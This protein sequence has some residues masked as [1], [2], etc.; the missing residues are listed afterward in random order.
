MIQPIAVMVPVCCP[1]NPSV[2]G[3]HV[4]WQ[5]DGWRDIDTIVVVGSGRARCLQ[6]GPEFEQLLARVLASES[7]TEAIAAATPELI[8]EQLEEDELAETDEM[9][10]V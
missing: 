2:A 9:E 5:P 8:R 7:C 4:L 1:D 3:V 10:V 6:D